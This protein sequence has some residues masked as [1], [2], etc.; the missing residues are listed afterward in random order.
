V[1]GLGFWATRTGVQSSLGLLAATAGPQG[2]VPTRQSGAVREGWE[3]YCLLTL[4]RQQG[5]QKELEAIL[6]AYTD[7]RPISDLR[8]AA[9]RALLPRP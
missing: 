7:G 5:K 4:L 3:D 1:D 6:K 9:L 2:P 8:L